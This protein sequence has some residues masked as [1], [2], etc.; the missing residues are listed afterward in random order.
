MGVFTRTMIRPGGTPAKRVSPR[1]EVTARCWRSS[2]V[3]ES[4][5]A[6]SLL[7]SITNQIIA[8]YLCQFGNTLISCVTLRPLILI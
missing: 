6:C 4:I 5:S 3:G 8:H 2:P 1:A 7:C